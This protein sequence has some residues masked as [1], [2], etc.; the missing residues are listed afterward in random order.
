[1]TK[2]VCQLYGC[3][4]RPKQRDVGL[5][6]KIVLSWYECSACQAVLSAEDWPDTFADDFR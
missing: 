3:Q 4:W 1:M 5:F 2:W 6:R